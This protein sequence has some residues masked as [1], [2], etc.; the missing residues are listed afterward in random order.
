MNPEAAQAYQELVQEYQREHIGIYDVSP[1]L[2][3]A[4]NVSDAYYGS[5]SSVIEL[6]KAAGK[7]VMVMDH[8]I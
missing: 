8:R 4:I 3:R 2:H 1:D 5:R 6:F 7:P